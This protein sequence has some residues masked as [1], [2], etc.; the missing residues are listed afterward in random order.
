MPKPTNYRIHIRT[1]EHEHA[2]FKEAA[3]V[4][5]F[6]TLSEFCRV[7]IYDKVRNC[8]L[9]KITTPADDYQEFKVQDYV[10][11]SEAQRILYQTESEEDREQRIKLTIDAL[12][13][14][15]KDHQEIAAA[16]QEYSQIIK[17]IEKEEPTE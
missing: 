8:N 6:S 12:N 15:D 3:K 9:Q 4:H 14:I 11:A 10:C 1:D 7:A 13:E 16:T 2:M 5:G 17:T